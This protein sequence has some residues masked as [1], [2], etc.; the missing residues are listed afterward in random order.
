[1][2]Y[3]Y[4]HNSS[5]Y[6]STIVLVVRQ[7]NPKGTKDWDD[8]VKQGVSVITPNP[9]TLGGARWKYLAACE[10]AKRNRGDVVYPSAPYIS[11]SI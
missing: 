7:G 11:I 8:L 6:T 9:K 1:M 5:P 10:F 4:S 3:Q 2:S